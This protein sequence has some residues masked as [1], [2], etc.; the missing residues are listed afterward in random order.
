MSVEDTRTERVCP[1]CQYP[2][3]PGWLHQE[4]PQPP[5]SN[6]TVCSLQRANGLI[7]RGPMI[8][9]LTAYLDEHASEDS[10]VEFS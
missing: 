10:T 1:R 4:R 5:G 2:V 3:R 7:L 8:E 9:V 6:V